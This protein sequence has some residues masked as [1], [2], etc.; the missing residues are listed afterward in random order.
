MTMTTAKT[1]GAGDLQDRRLRDQRRAKFGQALNEAMRA[2][3]W[4]Q[5][6]LATPLHTTQSSVSAWIHGK[7]VPH[8]DDV[9]EVELLLDLTPGSLSRHLGY[10][11]V[12]ADL[13]PADMLLTIINNPD[14]DAESK[15]L[16]TRFYKTLRAASRKVAANGN[17]HINGSHVK[18]PRGKHFLVEPEISAAITADGKVSSAARPSAQ[19][20]RQTSQ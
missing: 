14:L 18:L 6:D 7:N 1:S 4:N 13:A 8:A 5:G 19:R 10:Q 17:G 3:G 11:P 12:G 20:R 16:M 2:A 9:F 15:E